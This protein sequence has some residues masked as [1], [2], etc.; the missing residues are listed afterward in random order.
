MAEQ[1]YLVDLASLRY[2]FRLRLNDIKTNI[3]AVYVLKLFIIHCIQMLYKI[4]HRYYI[5][6]SQI[7]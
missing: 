3:I 6:G 5:W 2:F 1:Q 7:T 4:Y